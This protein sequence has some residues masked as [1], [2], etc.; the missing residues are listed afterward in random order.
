MPDVPSL[1]H[2]SFLLLFKNRPELAAELL[3]DVLHV[4]L[5]AYAEIRTDSAELIE[6]VPTSYHADVVV[7]LIDQV[8]VFAIIVEAQLAK[9][10]RKHYSWP[11]YATSLRAKFKCP[12]CVLVVTG[13]DAIAEWARTPINLGPSFG[14]FVPLVVGPTA[15][16]VVRDIEQAK[17]DPE[18]AVLSAMAHGKEE[19]GL[20][21]ALAAL[22]A[23]GALDVER[24]MLYLDLVGISLSDVA[25]AA[26]EDLMASQYEFQTEWAKKQK[27]SLDS[28][29][30]A[31]FAAGVAARV[32]VEAGVAARVA[33]AKA[34]AVLKFL[35]TRR[36]TVT[37]EQKSRILACTDLARLERWIE[38]A[39][40]LTTT[41]ELFTE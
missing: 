39:V 4:E 3:R 34:A 18:L 16:P 15:V 23:C 36:I 41:D 25:R 19:V 7:L 35:S 10:T 13:S 38:K 2:E 1:T 11:H 14:M 20:P 33:E 24:A 9:D 27:A 37:D 17:R 6:V 5:P 29:R 32:E 30:D 40:T 28:A 21:I 22:A 12:V 8:P 26:F 31:G